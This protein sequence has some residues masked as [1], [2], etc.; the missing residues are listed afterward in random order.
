ME[1]S[2][3]IERLNRQRR[4]WIDKTHELVTRLALASFEGNQQSRNDCLNDM[5]VAMNILWGLDRRLE[6]HVSDGGFE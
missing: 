6:K 5:T 4:Y 1:I 2:P 3:Q